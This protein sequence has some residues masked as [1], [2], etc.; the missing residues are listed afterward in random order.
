MQ[1]IRYF[2]TEKQRAQ[3]ADILASVGRQT[4]QQPKDGREWAFDELT[5]AAVMGSIGVNSVYDEG[6]VTLQN[7][8]TMKLSK[9]ELD[10]EVVGSDKKWLPEREGVKLNIINVTESSLLFN[11]L[12][13]G[14][15]LENAI[16]RKAGGNP[17]YTCVE[18][19]IDN[20]LNAALRDSGA[21][22][23]TKDLQEEK[24][25]VFAEKPK[26]SEKDKE[27]KKDDKQSAKPKVAE[28]E[29]AQTIEN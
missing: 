27:K 4:G 12:C 13:K 22:M 25:A 20:V 19:Y 3:L 8:Q 23:L 9:K 11:S 6:R 5:K 26:E 7:G 15:A 10:A 1:Q 24:R 18:A 17:R 28:S 16:T 2:Q 29:E 21:V 14:A